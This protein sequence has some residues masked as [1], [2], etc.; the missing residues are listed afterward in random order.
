MVDFVFV[1]QYEE[2]NRL[3]KTLYFLRIRFFCSGCLY[4]SDALNLHA[5]NFDAVV[6]RDNLT[7]FSRTP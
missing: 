4:F 1:I 2:P 3:P 5:A 7:V 6:D